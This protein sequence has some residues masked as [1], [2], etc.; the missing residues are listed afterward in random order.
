MRAMNFVIDQ[1]QIQ[2]FLGGL[3]LG[4]LL[5]GLVMKLRHDRDRSMLRSTLEHSQTDLERFQ[6]E[7]R[8]AQ[9]DAASL[10]R[11]NASL[12]A[13]LDSERHR[14]R[15]QLALLQKAR[16]DLTREFENLA[17]RIFEEKQANFNR[18]SKLAMDATVDPLRR[19]ILDFRRK[20]EDVYEKENAERNRLAGQVIELQKQAQRIGQD[21]LHLANALK[22]GSKIQ[23]NWGEVVLERILE[24]SGLRK[25]REYETQVNL[26]SDNGDRRNPDVI[27]HLPDNRDIVIDAKVS[28]TDYERY[29]RAENEDHRQSCL[30]AHLASLRGHVSGLS[31]KAYEQLEGINT[32]DFVLI[33][34]PVESAFTLAMEHDQTLFRDAYDRG[35][36]LVSPST[37]L[38]TLR[39]VNNIWRFDDQN[40]NARKIA[41]QAGAIHDQFVL[42]AESLEDVGRQ[43]DKSH[44]AWQLTRQRLVSGRGNLV[45]RL[46]DLKAMGARTRRSIP[47]DLRV[48]ALELED[49][50]PGEMVDVGSDS[51]GD[52]VKLQATRDGVTK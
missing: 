17:N 37:L 12:A 47:E 6:F 7:A 41:A 29:S 27:V 10:T 36:I 19:D 42:V 16:D 44:E 51:D 33:F 24:E 9:A 18:Q 8:R 14:F 23:G 21:A 15:E 46:E 4:A 20:V 2:I 39:T 35:I 11:E 1:L 34:L 49:C 5:V 50:D 40:R 22:G 30:K 45:R 25:G 32:L 26:R 38:A 13:T 31:R 28:L 43:I 48:A 3:A 52:V